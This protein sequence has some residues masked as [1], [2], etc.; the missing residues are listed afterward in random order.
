MTC[1]LQ[2]TVSSK[3]LLGEFYSNNL[4]DWSEL[5]F[6]VILIEIKDSLLPPSWVQNIISPLINHFSEDE[7]L[8]ILPGFLDS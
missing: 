7:L 6:I 8:L 4:D 1:W 2:F 5:N 3:H